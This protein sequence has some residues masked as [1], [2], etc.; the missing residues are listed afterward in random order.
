MPQI[1]QDYLRLKVSCQ[2]ILQEDSTGKPYHLIR[3]ITDY[4]FRKMRKYLDLLSEL[5]NHLENGDLESFS[6][7]ELAAFL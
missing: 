3:T 4:Q 2:R 7:S 5:T 1:L 6:K